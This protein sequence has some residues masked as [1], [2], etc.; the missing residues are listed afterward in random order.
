MRYTH[1]LTEYLKLVQEINDARTVAEH[2]DANSQL[3]G[4]KRCLTAMGW[5]AGDI[6]NLIMDG[7]SYF[8][9]H[10]VDRP[11]CGGVFLDWEPAEMAVA[12]G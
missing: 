2:M 11:M 9:A 10:G 1:I 8:L 12:H 6:G 5:K 3:I 7:D 4:L